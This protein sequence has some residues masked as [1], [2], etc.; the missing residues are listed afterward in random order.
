VQDAFD[1]PPADVASLCVAFSQR[2]WE[3]PFLD[4]V[5]ALV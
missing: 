5:Y 1:I 4:P 3:E 2:L